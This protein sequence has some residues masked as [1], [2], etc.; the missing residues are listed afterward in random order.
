MKIGQNLST[1][2]FHVAI[3][4]YTKDANFGSSYPF[5]IKVVTPDHVSDEEVDRQINEKDWRE[6]IITQLCEF[7]PDAKKVKGR[8]YIPSLKRTVEVPEITWK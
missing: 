7:Y 8:V 3:F 4:S 2:D 5:Q 6:I 1:P